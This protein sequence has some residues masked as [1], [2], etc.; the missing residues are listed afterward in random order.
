MSKQ[1]YEYQIIYRVI[2]KVCAAEIHFTSFDK[3]P[4]QGV[5]DR[6]MSNNSEKNETEF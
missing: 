2:P 1:K 5:S 3:S 6:P 4:K